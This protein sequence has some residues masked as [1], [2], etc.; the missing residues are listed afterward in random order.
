M[1]TDEQISKD[2]TLT[3]LLTLGIFAL[4]AKKKSIVVTNYLVIE[5]DCGGIQTVA[6]FT[7][8]TAPELNSEILKKRM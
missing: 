3:R 7:G 8:N 6:A 2:V 4:G 5:Y 1:K